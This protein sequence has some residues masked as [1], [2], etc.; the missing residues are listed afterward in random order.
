MWSRLFSLVS[1][2]L[3]AGCLGEPTVGQPTPAAE[4]PPSAPASFTVVAGGDILIH[5]ALTAQAEADG[6]G[7]R[8]YAPLFAG[9]KPVLDRADVAVCHLEV[10]IADAAGPF[11]GYPRFNAPP[12]LAAGLAASG[13]DTCSTASN[14][15]LDQG[16]AG[17][18]KTLDALDAAKITH[19]G[20]ARSAREAATPLIR[21]VAGARVGFLSY[22]FGLNQGTTRPAASPWLANLLDPAAVL[23]EARAARAAGAEIVVASLHW[24]AESRH[25]PTADQ[26]LIAKA[27]LGDP[28]VDLIIGHHAHV[29]QPFEKV[30]GKWVAYGLGNLVAKHEQPKGVTEEGVLARFRFTKS[31]ARWTVDKAEYIPTL[32]DLGP[33]IRLRDLTSDT[34]S[35]TT[36]AADRKADALARTEGIVLGRGAGAAGLTRP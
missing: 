14:H 28:A 13:F 15:T 36:V 3:L 7:A 31:G 27:L 4:P 21:E 24:G 34:T 10:P 11:R 5:P 26:V 9:V 20:S 32:V 6:G 8:D 17:V 1:G 25:E 19:T 12:E 30:E 35:D 16:P 22:T 33:P 2:V 29:V 23:A 18:A